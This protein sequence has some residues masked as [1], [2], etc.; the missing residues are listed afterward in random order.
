MVIAYFPGAGGNRYLQRLLKRGWTSP[1]ISYDLHSKDQNLQH[2]YLIGN[3]APEHGPYVL[4]HCMDIKKIKKFFQDMPVVFIKSRLQVSLQR[5]WSLHG[6]RNF[7]KQ[8]EVGHVSKLEHYCAVRDSTWPLITSEDQLAHLPQH[9][10]QEINADYFKIISAQTNT[11]TKLSRLTK[12]IISQ[13]NSAYET[14]AWHRDYY[15]TY[16]ADFTGADQIIDIDSDN[17]DFCAVMRQEFQRYHSD[18]F[19]Q[20]WDAVHEQ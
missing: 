13:I 7:Q 18:I 15:Q 19:S 4:T 14:I 16:P 8:T 1:G 12:N 6:H 2:R 10:Q 5:E 17:L 3:V 11:T 20:A 9:I